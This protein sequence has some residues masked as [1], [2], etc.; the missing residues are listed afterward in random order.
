LDWI[1]PLPFT[2]RVVTTTRLYG[3]DT[4]VPSASNNTVPFT[5]NVGVVST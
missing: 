3:C 2:V 4:V 5:V 1:A